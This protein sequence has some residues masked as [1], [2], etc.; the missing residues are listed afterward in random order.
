MTINFSEIKLSRKPLP[1]RII[2]Y[3]EP[4]IGKSKFCSNI[5]NAIFLDVEGGTG[6]LDIR[7]VEREFLS[8]WADICAALDGL[9]VQEHD[10]Q[11]AIIDTADF[12]EKVLQLQAATEHDVRTFAKIGYGKGDVSVANMWREVT[13]K[14]DALRERR[15]M[16]IILI[17]HE[18]VKK[19]TEPEADSSYDRFTLAVSP[20]SAEL[21]EAWADAILF[22]KVEV[23]TSKKKEGLKE[24]VTAVEG[25]RVLLTRN[26]PHHL[27]G[28]RYNLPEVLPFTWEAFSQAFIEATK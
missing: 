21:L 10:F 26:A 4:K 12:M 14:L 6:H 8:T 25:D 2:L 3:G 27:A 22:A 13:Q 20:K 11:A 28:N 1:P 15:G 23:Y 9:L 18:T 16:A 17:A 24:K 5:P 19:V 7:R